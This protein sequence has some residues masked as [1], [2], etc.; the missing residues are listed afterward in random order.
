[1]GHRLRQGHSVNVIRFPGTLDAPQMV[2]MKSRLTRVLNQHPRLLLLDL[3]A[4]HRIEL[5]GLGILIDR[6]HRAVNGSGEVRF[7]NVSPQVHRTLVRAGVN[8]LIAA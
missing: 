4:T 3:G 5:A 7:S 1:M 2:R 6:L 8:A